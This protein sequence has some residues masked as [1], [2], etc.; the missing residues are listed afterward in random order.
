MPLRLAAWRSGP[1]ALSIELETG[2]GALLSAPWMVEFYGAVI[3]SWNS[4]R[5]PRPNCSPS[6]S[7][8]PGPAGAPES[9][10]GLSAEETWI[11][12]LVTGGEPGSWSWV[13]TPPWS[14]PAA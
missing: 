11:P 3:R 14:G 7:A 5:P 4:F 8:A 10:L 6:D 13:G 2:N 1:G 12:Q 9:L